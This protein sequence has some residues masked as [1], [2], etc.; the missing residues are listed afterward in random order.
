MESSARRILVVNGKGGCGKTT[1]ATNLAVAY[2]NSGAKVA[3][4]DND[5]QASSTHWAS[6]RDE[7]LPAIEVVAKHER[8]IIPIQ[9][10]VEILWKVVLTYL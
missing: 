3:L 9:R 6:V 4:L 8:P 2:A 5:P 1:I 10:H 7:G